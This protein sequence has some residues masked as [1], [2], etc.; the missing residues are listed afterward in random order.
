MV[1]R[2]VLFT[3]NT[4]DSGTPWGSATT[5]TKG[6]GT[7][8]IDAEETAV[9]QASSATWKAKRFV[10]EGTL[11][12]NGTLATNG[13]VTAAAAGTG[14]VVFTGRAPTPAGDAWWKNSLWQGTVKIADVSNMVGSGSG[15]VLDFN[16]YGNTGSF[17]EPS[18]VTG[19]VSSGYNCTVPLKISGLTINNGYSNT[20]TTFSKVTGEGDLT[21][22]FGGS[23]YK[24]VIGVLTNFTGTIYSYYASNPVQIETLELPETPESGT[25]LVKVGSSYNYVTLTSVKIGQET[26]PAASVVKLQD[27]DDGYGFYFTAS[28]LSYEIDEDTV[29]T[30]L[31][32]WA[33]DAV[34]AIRVTG[35]CAL[36]IPEGT[37]IGALNLTL[38]DGVTLSFANSGTVTLLTAT[39]ANG[40]LRF[41][42]DFEIPAGFTGDATVEVADGV[43]LT[44]PYVNISSDGTT[45]DYAGAFTGGE[46][47]TIAMPLALSGHGDITS[48]E[49][50]NSLLKL[51]DPEGWKGTLV[52]SGEVG[53]FAL[54][55]FG[56]TN[57]TVRIDGLASDVAPWSYGA[58]M[59][60]V[61]TLEIGDGGWTLKASDYT[62]D[63]I[64]IPAELTGEGTLTVNATGGARIFFTGDVSAFAGAV[65]IGS[66]AAVQVQFI[67]RADAEATTDPTTLD[68]YVDYAANTVAVAKGATVYVSKAWT[69]PNGWTGAGRIVFAAP[70]LVNKA[71]ADSWTGTVELAAIAPTGKT[72]IWLDRMASANSVFVLK[73]IQP[74]TTNRIDETAAECYF[75][76]HPGATTATAGTM[77]L[78]G[79]VLLT[80]G[81]SSANYRVARL[82]GMRPGELCTMRWADIERRDTVW[83]YRPADHKNKW[84]RH[85]RAVVI[86]PRAQH[87]MSLRE[88]EGEYVFSPRV[89]EAERLEAMRLARKTK[90]Q[91]SQLNRSK[92]SPL[93]SPGQRWS[94][95]SYRRAIERKCSELGIGHWHPNQ[96][97]HNCATMVRRAFG[98]DAARAVLGHLHGLAITDRYSFE[99]A[100]DEQIAVA[101]PAMIALG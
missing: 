31:E 97:R 3:T 96:L 10:V 80:D 7:I 44:A 55:Q 63:Q 51:N 67:D 38:D 39:G 72:A 85:P 100:E 60:V 95:D 32:G 94:T 47:A 73:G 61:K 88:G 71:V 43:T 57:S 34:A 101:M 6:D 25:L 23:N 48:Y 93:R 42:S 70:Y 78:D 69:V 36:T 53:R 21:F 76:V 62:G 82:T 26:L 49:N 22:N 58:D 54:K 66:S 29:I 35:S 14:T 9:V 75:A 15:T 2:T 30:E 84:R 1:T 91:P 59:H 17:L 5:Y 64:V 20:T 18:N 33:D 27:G 83:V 28:Q 13:T 45:S 79:D 24:L 37:S 98:I 56:N 41:A 77:Q 12:A 11:E 52:L 8:Y 68:G 81:N 19:W 74:G 50:L 16:S 89:A 92:E 86:G 4:A 40:T 46:G 90:V 87:L 99:A 65:A